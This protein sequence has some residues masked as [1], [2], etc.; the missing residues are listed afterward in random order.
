[1]QISASEWVLG[2]RQTALRRATAA[3]FH[4]I[5]LDAVPHA[6]I[7]QLQDALASAELAVPSLCWAW[8]SEHELGSPDASSRSGAQ[9]FL[10]AALEQ[11]HELGSSQVVVLPACRNEPWVDEPRLRGLERAAESISQVLVDA[12]K[13]ITIALEGL[14]RSESFLMNTLDHSAL[15][16]EM[17]GADDRVGLLADWYH[18]V[19]EE[20]DPI[21]ALQHHA[22]EITLVH[23]AARARGPLI[24]TTAG[25]IELVEQLRTMPSVRSFTLEFTV[26]D[27]DA[28][29]ADARDFASR[30]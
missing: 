14:R 20:I 3:G 8:N 27:N 4:A 10:L 29:L 26:G 18:L 30:I 2:D 21:A 17:I 25:A 7:H 11:A 9:D 28:S 16:R 5:E 23:L 12:P 22:E 15:L 19:T 24:E 1:M 13:G 6:D